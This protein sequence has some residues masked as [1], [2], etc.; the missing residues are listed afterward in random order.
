[1]DGV[2]GVGSKE[3]L[4]SLHLKIPTPWTLRMNNVFKKANKSILFCREMKEIWAECKL[5][6]SSW[7]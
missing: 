6:V 1:M 5:C 4:S 7:C 2:D 3:I